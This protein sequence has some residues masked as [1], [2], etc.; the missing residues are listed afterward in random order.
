[1]EGFGMSKITKIKF[2]KD[3]KYLLAETTS[4][5]TDFRPEND[6]HWRWITLSTTGLLTIREGYGWDGPSGPVV[7]RSTNMRAS[8]CHDALYQLMRQG[9]LPHSDWRKADK[10]YAK[11]LK[12]DGA[13]ALTIWIDMQGLSLAGGTAAKPKNA[14]RCYSAP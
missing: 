9:M 11:L 3:I 1:M 13:W 7:D 12:E 8:L 5:Q 2:L 4:F 14:R 10:E 6:I